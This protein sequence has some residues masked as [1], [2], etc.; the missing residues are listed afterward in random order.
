MNAS[1]QSGVRGLPPWTVEVIST[2]EGLLERRED[3]NRLAERTAGGNVFQTFDWAWAWW[4][5]IGRNDRFW[6]PKRL[7]VLAF[8]AGGELSGLAPLIRRVASWGPFRLRKIELLGARSSDYNDLLFGDNP[9]ECI[10]AML[11]H[12]SQEDDW[13]LVDLTNVPADSPTHAAFLSVLPETS[14]HYSVQPGSHCPYIRI[15]GNLKQYVKTRSKNFRHAFRKSQKRLQQLEAAGVQFRMIEEPHLEPDLLPKMIAVENRKQIRRGI[16]R[17]ILAKAEPFFASVFQTLG[18]SGRLYVAVFEKSGQLIAY[19]FGFR[20]GGKLWNYNTAHD[21]AYARCSPGKMLV[22]AT[23]EFAH[24]QGYK[25][26]DFLAG[27]EDFKKKWTPELHRNVRILI[28]SPQLRSRVTA[29]LHRHVW[30]YLRR[31]A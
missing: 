21:S 1:V 2:G 28:W 27:E 29:A 31:W 19:Q 3:W 9:H 7:H 22:A 16:A 8:R 4:Q 5:H 12:L 25:E 24:Q 14:L 13:D 17:P 23:L 10:Q 15:E 20:C 30:P 11:A 6:G 18:P 26:Y